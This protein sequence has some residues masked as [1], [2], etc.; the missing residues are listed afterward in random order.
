MMQKLIK[1]SKKTKKKTVA[2]SCKR[3][4]IVLSFK[5][6]KKYLSSKHEIQCKKG[7]CIYMN[8]YI[9]IYIYIYSCGFDCYF[10]E[11]YRLFLTT[12]IKNSNVE[13]P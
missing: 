1:T 13:V 2:V 10:I 6:Y 12:I 3:S 4:G 5:F 7:M 11:F 9:Y 8:I